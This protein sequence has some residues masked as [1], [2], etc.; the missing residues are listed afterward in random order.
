LALIRRIRPLHRTLL[1]GMLCTMEHVQENRELA[2]L[3]ESEGLDVQLAYD[4][5]HLQMNLY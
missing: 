4:G 3:R 5:M 1:V 2:K